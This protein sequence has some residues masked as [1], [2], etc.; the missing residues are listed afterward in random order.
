MCRFHHFLGNS[1]HRVGVH[2]HVYAE[3]HKQ[4]VEHYREKPRA[5][6][7]HQSAHRFAGEN[8]HDFGQRD[9]HKV[10][11]DKHHDYRT[12]YRRQEQEHAEEAESELFFAYVI[13]KQQPQRRVYAGEQQEEQQ[14]HLHRFDERRAGR[15]HLQRALY[16]VERPGE[17]S[18]QLVITLKRVQYAVELNGDIEH[19]ELQNRPCHHQNVKE[20]VSLCRARA[21]FYCIICHL[22]SLS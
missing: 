21:F 20:H 15:H 2:Q 3:A 14:R 12:D 7:A 13:G 17:R 18:A 16:I 9:V 1:R 10:A 4:V 22:F 8:A 6:G 11:V 19:A 5:L